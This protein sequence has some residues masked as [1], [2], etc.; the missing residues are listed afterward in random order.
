M[1]I[2]ELRKLVQ[3][4]LSEMAKPASGLQLA[5]DW[6]N[7]WEEQP[8]SIKMSVRYKRII[9]YLKEHGTGTLGDIALEK[10][11]SSD[12]AVCN[13]L[14]KTLIGL[15]IVEN[16]GYVTPLKAKEKTNPEGVFGRP[17]VTNEETKMLGLNIIRKFSKGSTDFTPE[18]RELITKMYDSIQG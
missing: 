2:S 11:N 15:G 16:T 7:K 9:D 13:Q 5:A 14:V 6:E 8:D 17:K 4:S 3:E 18:E 12:T 1:K 10:F